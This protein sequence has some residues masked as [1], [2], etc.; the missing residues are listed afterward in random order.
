MKSISKIYTIIFFGLLIFISCNKKME[1]NN[2]GEELITTLIYTLVPLDGGDSVVL[3][4]QDTDGEGGNEP[5]II[6]E[7]L[8]PNVLYSGTISLLNESM[9]PAENIGLEVAAENEEHQMFYQTD[10]V[11]LTIEYADIDANGNP[12]GL[13]T[14]LNTGD[15]G[16]GNLT[17]TLR[18]EPE[19]TANGVA[20]GDITNADGETDIEVTF[21][22]TIQ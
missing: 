1:I 22:I 15:A 17:I 5:V 7:T 4:F 19:K 12:L 3:S 20:D 6:T 11:D 9:E 10:G 8:S 21:Q 16:I 18:H 14:M 13:S 2:G